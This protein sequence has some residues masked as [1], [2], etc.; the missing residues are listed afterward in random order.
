M[1]AK[2]NK[3]TVVTI[4]ARTAQQIAESII[5]GLEKVDDAKESVGEV[6]REAAEVLDAITPKFTAIKWNSCKSPEST[7]AAFAAVGVTD[8]QGKALQ[9]FRAVI[10]EAAKVFNDAAAKTVW[11][12]IARWSRGYVGSKPLH[13][14]VKPTESPKAGKADKVGKATT[15]TPVRDLIHA[16]PQQARVLLGELVAGFTT[17]KGACK[18]NK[19]SAALVQ[20]VLDLLGETDAAIAALK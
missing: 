16:D 12:S 19:V 6:Y 11:Q 2:T 17:L 9:E 18:K 8:S 1:K 14:D 10:L 5:K 7:K 15:A 20:E 3:A 13:P 4:K